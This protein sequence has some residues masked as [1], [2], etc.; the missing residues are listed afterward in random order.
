MLSAAITDLYNQDAYSVQIVS[1][2]L[3]ANDKKDRLSDCDARSKSE[4]TRT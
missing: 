4:P 1:Y 3:I 2:Q